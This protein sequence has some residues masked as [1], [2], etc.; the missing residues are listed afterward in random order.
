MI[1]EF[2]I[3]FTDRYLSLNADALEDGEPYGR[4]K[5]LLEVKQANAE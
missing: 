3:Q 2:E 4:Y 1:L 5:I